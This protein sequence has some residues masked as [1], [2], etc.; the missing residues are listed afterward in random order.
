MDT[1]PTNLTV[2]PDCGQV[3]VR[4]SAPRTP[5]CTGHSSQK[6]ASA[7]GLQ[8]CLNWRRKG[9]FVCGFHGGKTKAAEAKGAQRMERE[10]AAA[11]I[12]Q[13]TGE[14]DVD[15]PQSVIIGQLRSR[16]AQS[17]FWRARVAE[18]A[19]DQNADALLRGTRGVSRTV[20]EMTGGELGDT[21]TESTTTDVGPLLHFALVEWQKAQD[22]LES[23]ALAAIKAGLD[24]RRLEL[25]RQQATMLVDGL[26]WM[27]GEA[28]L[29]LDLA[30]AESRVLGDLVM[31][32]LQRLDGLETPVKV[33]R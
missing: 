23:L 13:L 16:A 10:R 18:L 24:E 15:D 6:S 12:V 11:L 26:R 14:V 31:E 4:P 27:Q 9:Q 1:S 33:G 28:R 7:G 22:K 3:H 30:E 2:C 29:R 19:P 21:H 5:T 20:T 8:P 25:E 17:A 32:M